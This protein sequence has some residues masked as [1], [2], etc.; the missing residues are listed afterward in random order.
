MCP[1]NSIDTGSAEVVSAATSVCT[2]T[3]R[4]LNISNA[5][6]LPTDV[7]V[8]SDK[9][10]TSLIGKATRGAVE[11]VV[12]KVIQDFGK[13]WSGIVI[14]VSDDS[15]ATISGGEN[16]G[17]KVNDVF[18]VIRKGEAIVNPETGETLGSEDKEIGEIAVTEVK[19]KYALAFI[20]KGDKDIKAGDKIKKEI[21]DE[22]K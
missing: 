13:N 3:S 7:K 10:N 12:S 17:V 9:F 18:K 4:G 11:D 6:I 20:I 1:L 19:P 15:T 2:K 14:K 21:N 8:G 22:A 5:S 16:V